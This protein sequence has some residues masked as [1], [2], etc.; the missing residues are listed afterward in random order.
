MQFNPERVDFFYSKM[1]VR[2]AKMSYPAPAEDMT[3]RISCLGSV[4]DFCAGSC[5]LWLK[6][7]DAS[8]TDINVVWKVV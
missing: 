3:E 7:L 6:V 4:R 5:M 1:L 8:E 2:E